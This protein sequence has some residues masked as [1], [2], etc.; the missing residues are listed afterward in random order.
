MLKYT[1]FSRMLRMNAEILSI[2]WSLSLDRTYR[3]TS[4]RQQ[5][6]QNYLSYEILSIIWSPSSDKTYRTT[7]HR[8]KDI[9]DYFS[10]IERH[11]ELLL[12]DRKTSRITSTTQR[13]YPSHGV[14]L[15]TRYPGLLLIDRKTSR[16]ERYP[17]L[18]ISAQILSITWSLSSDK[19]SRITSHRQKDIQNYFYR[20][21][22]PECRDLIHHM[23]SVFRQDIQD[24]FS[25]IERYP[26]LFIPN[27]CIY[28]MCF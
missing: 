9:Q 17:E 18:F 23:E 1:F 3:T 14:C 13:S 16:I 19:I 10:Q 11:P 28:L 7:S 15:Q 2:T 22:Y 5:D 12:L 26:E 8:Y 25:Q 27:G 20:E 24:Y 4:H 21:R 6:I